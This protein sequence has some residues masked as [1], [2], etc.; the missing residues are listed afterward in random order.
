MED[1]SPQSHP[2]GH[3]NRW[4]WQ[5]SGLEGDAKGS[6]QMCVLRQVISH[7]GLQFPHLTRK[8]L[9]PVLTHAPVVLECFITFT[10]WKLCKNISKQQ[11]AKRYIVLKENYKHC[12]IP[13]I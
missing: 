8:K 11:Q 12:I 9:S 13:F 1:F 4:E 2:A 10:K 7:C 3:L 6:E 5:G